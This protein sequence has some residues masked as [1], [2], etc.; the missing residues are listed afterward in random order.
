MFNLDYVYTDTRYSKSSSNGRKG[1][2]KDIL[3]EK[4]LLSPCLL[5]ALIRILQFLEA[6]ICEAKTQLKK[7]LKPKQ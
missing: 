2:K 7:K 4:V 3:M 5:L 1:K 6:Q